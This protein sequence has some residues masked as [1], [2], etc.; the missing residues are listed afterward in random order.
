MSEPKVTGTYFVLP[1][2]GHVRVRM[3]KIKV[4]NI[5]PPRAIRQGRY[6]DTGEGEPLDVVFEEVFNASLPEFRADAIL[7]ILAKA[8][9]ASEEEILKHLG[10]IPSC[11]KCGDTLIHEESQYNLGDGTTLCDTCFRFCEDEGWET[12]P[13]DQRYKPKDLPVPKVLKKLFKGDALRQFYGMLSLIMQ[14]LQQIP[15]HKT[16]RTKIDTNGEIVHKDDWKRY[17]VKGVKPSGEEVLEEFPYLKKTHFL[18]IIE[19]GLNCT[20]HPRIYWD[21]FKTLNRGSYYEVT[22]FD[23]AG[24]FAMWNLGQKYLS[25][26]YQFPDGT[27]GEAMV[28]ID[29]YHATSGTT[30]EYIALLAPLIYIDEEG[31]EKFIWVM[32]TTQ[33][34]IAYSGGMD[35]PK[36]GEVPRTVPAQRTVLLNKSFN[37]MLEGLVKA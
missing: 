29:G 24:K 35:I 13:K 4:E 19:K 10:L 37:D 28:V 16:S 8:G 18:P 23:D 27:K 17:L 30:Q 25:G 33:T 31:V 36:P 9:V 14:Q 32:K 2:G 5:N 20:V 34:R 12:L 22:A 1:E 6:V 21:Q 3:K 11:A 26:E 7:R 15:L